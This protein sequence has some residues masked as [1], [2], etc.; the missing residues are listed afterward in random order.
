[1]V[2]YAPTENSRTVFEGKPEL[3]TDLQK[4]KKKINPNELLRCG[5][6]CESM[7]CWFV[8]ISKF[9]ENVQTSKKARSIV[10][11]VVET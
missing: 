11:L 5:E 2:E 3:G 6:N 1:M 8:T 4:A 7:N 9:P 10:V